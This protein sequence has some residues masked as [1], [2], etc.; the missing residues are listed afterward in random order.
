MAEAVNSH[1]LPAE[2]SPSLTGR[3]IG[4]L[5]VPMVL[6]ALALGIAGAISV[7][8]AVTT[9]SDTILLASSHAIAETL[10]VDKGEV[11]LDLPPS[12]FGMLEN[13]AQD[14]VYYTIHHKGQV[15]T[16]YADLPLIGAGLADGE[17]TFIDDVYRGQPIRLVAEARRL[18]RLNGL[19]VVEVAE[20]TSGR[21]VI[22]RHILW[23]LGSLEGALI[24]LVLVLIPLAIRWGLHP[25]VRL[26]AT[27]DSRNAQ[28][29]TPIPL[30]Q[31]PAELRGLVSSFN[32]LLHR[33]DLAVEGVRR[34]SADASHQMR[35][36]LSVLRSHVALLKKASPPD[37]TS[38]SSLHD[39]D[40]AVDR[41]ERLVT[42]LLALGRVDGA[43]PLPTAQTPCNLSQLVQ[44]AASDLAM[45]A[46]RRRV[47]LALEAPA[48]PVWAMTDEP[49]AHEVI[50]NL[51]DNAIRY[52]RP[53]GHVTLSVFAADG[54]ARVSIEDDGP[55][56]PPADRE[57]VFERFIRLSP[58]ADH[59][60][61]GLGLAIA[62]T[63]GD[64]LG[65]HITLS[66]PENGQ[67]LRVVVDF[68][69]ADGEY[70]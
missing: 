50:T 57:R 53:R 59:S 23:I 61:S 47:N 26:R 42:Q 1:A 25:L 44:E 20:T 51:I 2:R 4:G 69:L 32:A 8:H 33:L 46:T 64:T 31:A 39:I 62:R 30:A 35:T 36:P 13:N 19:I 54:R 28:D 12:A 55:G 70:A 6:L 48:Y 24:L 56:I 49:L 63:L 16:G 15:I 60:G 67:G 7:R 65:A 34:F 18:P 3:L 27:M 14:N 37:K 22:S 38:R 5:I 68:P 45:M 10:A 9:V 43:T 17:H 66:T 21:T 40:E 52:N 11:T 29:F 41:L 58:D